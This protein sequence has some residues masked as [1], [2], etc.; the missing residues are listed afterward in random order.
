MINRTAKQHQL[1]ED[2]FGSDSEDDRDNNNKEINDFLEGS[3]DDGPKI[4]SQRHPNKERDHQGGH[5]KLMQ[6]Y[7]NKDATDND[8]D[9]GRRFWMR[10]GLFIR[11]AADVEAIC[12]YFDK[13]KVCCPSSTI[14]HS[15]PNY[16][17][18]FLSRTVR[19]S[20]ACHAFRISASVM[21]KASSF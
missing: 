16:S 5:A 1:L 14:F 13:K 11:I 8:A 12:P 18:H 10:R 6:D 3:N 19:A 21:P 4:W 9:F 20:G 7:F 17:L 2:L 15:H